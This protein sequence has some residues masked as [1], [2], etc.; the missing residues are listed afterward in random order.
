MKHFAISIF[1]IIFSPCAFSAT[2]YIYEGDL[3]NDGISDSLKS[4]PLS[5]FGKGNGPFVLKLSTENNKF[6]SSLIILNIN[7]FHLE[8]TSKINKIWSYYPITVEEGILR[9]TELGS[10]LY[11]VNKEVYKGD[12]LLESVLDRKNL[13]NFKV[14]ENYT[15]PPHPCGH[16]WG[17]GG[18]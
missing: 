5:L 13:I 4:G 3:N 9:S 1:L 14:I 6:N 16:Q 2:G 15:P 18:C 17:K 7:G 8:R 10:K 12:K 11:T